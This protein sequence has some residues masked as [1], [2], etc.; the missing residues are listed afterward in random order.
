MFNYRGVLGDRALVRGQWKG[1][2]LDSV[3]G[4]FLTQNVTDALSSKAYMTLAARF[5]ATIPPPAWQD[6]PAPD[7]PG[8][9]ETLHEDSL[10][11]ESGKCAADCSS[12][13]TKCNV[14]RAQH[15][16][17]DS[18]AAQNVELHVQSDNSLALVCGMPDAQHD[19]MAP[20]PSPKRPAEEAAI[21]DMPA[22]RPRTQE[23]SCLHVSLRYIEK[24]TS[25]EIGL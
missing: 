20:M 7:P 2:I 18:L 14:P 24:R 6:S 10:A 11:P 4:A 16:S 3:V 21:A 9:P 23:V 15:D 8:D 17:L 25:G 1:S 13:A 5:S 12:L 22:K 19:I